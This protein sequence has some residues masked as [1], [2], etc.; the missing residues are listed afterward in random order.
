MMLLQTKLDY[1]RFIQGRKFEREMQ[2][3]SFCPLAKVSPGLQAPAG[4][5]LR[6]L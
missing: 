5:R 1:N 4:R 2:S 6:K 3:V